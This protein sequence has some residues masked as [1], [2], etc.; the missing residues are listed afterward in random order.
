VPAEQ[1]ETT[2]TNERG[3]RRLIT[4]TVTSNKMDKTVVVTVIRRFRDKKFHKFVN[5]RVRYQAHDE[6][7]ACGVGDLV[8]LVESRPYSKTKRWRVTRTV[9]KAREGVQ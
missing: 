8:E 4:G 1:N 7:N 9:E 2:E 6:T 5:R 3:I